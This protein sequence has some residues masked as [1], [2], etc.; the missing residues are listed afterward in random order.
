ML[1]V[2]IITAIFFFIFSYANYEIQEAKK[3][4][5]ICKDL[6]YDGVKFKG[7]FSTEVECSNFTELD[8]VKKEQGRLK[9]MNFVKQ[10]V[11]IFGV[12][13]SEMEK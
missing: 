8:K 2:M 10:N 6:G 11:N 13:N 7:A 1:T 5:E 12:K 3:D 9:W 4:L